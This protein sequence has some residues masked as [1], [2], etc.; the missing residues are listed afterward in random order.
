MEQSIRYSIRRVKVR[1]WHAWL[2][3]LISDVNDLKVFN[4]VISDARARNSVYLPV[5]AKT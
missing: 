4:R 1:A 2:R 5:A 3:D